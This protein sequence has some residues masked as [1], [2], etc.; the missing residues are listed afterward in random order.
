MRHK[1]EFAAE[2]AVRDLQ[3]HSQKGLNAMTTQKSKGSQG[4]AANGWDATKS[5]EQYTGA[6]RETFEAFVKASTLATEG[7]GAMGQEWI[8]FGRRAMEQNATAA[9]AMLSAKSLPDFLELQGDWA[10]NAFEGYVAKT[11]KLS[12]MALKTANE[13]AAPIQSHVDDLVATFAKPAA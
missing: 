9:K 2:R 8:E 5:F 3:Q 13:A 12:E 11:T 1:T 10:K 6:G 7:Y 4:A